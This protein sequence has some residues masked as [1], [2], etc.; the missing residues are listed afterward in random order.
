[1]WTPVL[2]EM[3]AANLYARAATNGRQRIKLGQTTI[4]FAYIERFEKACG[5]TVN[6]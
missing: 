5:L 1:M 2:P 3:R 4:S 6:E